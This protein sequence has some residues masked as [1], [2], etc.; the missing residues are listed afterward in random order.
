[1]PF[2]RKGLLHKHLFSSC[3]RAQDAK[4]Q[5][6][7]H[8]G[9]PGHERATGGADFAA[10]VAKKAVA[11]AGGASGST[12]ASASTAAPAD[13][14][15]AA[16]AAAAGD[17]ASTSGC[18]SSVIPALYDV[19]KRTSA[20]C[21]ATAA[22]MLSCDAPSTSYPTTSLEEEWDMLG[23][24]MTTAQEMEA[25]VDSV[26]E[27]S[28]KSAQ[29]LFARYDMD[30]DAR[31]RQ[32]DYY[33]L[34]L[35]L[36]LALPYQE[37]QRFVDASFAYA[38][39]DH[40][41]FMTLADF[42]PLYKTIAAVRRAFRRQDHHNNGQIDRYDFYQLLV[43]LELSDQ[44]DTQQQLQNL[45][46]TAFSAADTTGRGIVNFGQTLVWYSAYLLATSKQRRASSRQLLEQLEA[47]QWQ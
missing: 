12:Q 17:G 27:G 8:Q 15:A 22:D 33:D 4:G 45:A 18:G 21:G 42:V 9:P 10:Q 24:C 46:D 7:R 25:C 11:A 31:L 2:S 32:Q 38:D 3:F 1:M 30:L 35:E 14:A 34:M 40:D 47:Q 6:A 20:H 41:G 26:L 5:N 19:P 13:T 36:A 23:A 37:Y 29:T 39:S 43:E 16:V 44:R 28:V